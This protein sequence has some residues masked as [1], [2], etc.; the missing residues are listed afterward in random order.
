M[1]NFLKMVWRE[2]SDLEM[3]AK[4]LDTAKRELL[5]SSSQ[6]EFYA[7][8]IQFNEARIRRLERYLSE[9]QRSPERSAADSGVVS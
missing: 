2:P 7:A 1:R 6:V 9:A 5:H 8:L 4:E 3:A